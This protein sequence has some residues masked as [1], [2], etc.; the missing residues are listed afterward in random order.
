MSRQYLEHGSQVA[1]FQ[2]AKLQEHKYPELKMLFAIP[3]GFQGNSARGKWMRDEGL[4]RG[5][6][7]MML[8]VP[9]HFFCGL[10]IEMKSPKGK[11]TLKQSEWQF[12]LRKYGYKVH[13]C[14]SQDEAI[15]TIK[16]YLGL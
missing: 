4:K 16:E 8:A 9:I 12:N 2:W 14:Y 13:V 5:V 6:P 10:L 3:N 11:L 15:N 7:D 1:V